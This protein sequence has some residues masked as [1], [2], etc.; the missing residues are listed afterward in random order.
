MNA[1]EVIDRA[2]VQGRVGRREGTRGR[3]RRRGGFTLLEAALALVILGVG[4]LALIESQAMFFA[5]NRY[6]TSAA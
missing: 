3:S 2:G 6:S 5:H 1:H 4:V